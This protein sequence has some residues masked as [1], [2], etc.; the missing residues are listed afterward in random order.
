LEGVE[1]TDNEFAQV[2]AKVSQ[3]DNSFEASK[4]LAMEGST[5]KIDGIYRDDNPKVTRKQITLTIFK[6][7]EVRG[8]DSSYKIAREI[9]TSNNNRFDIVLLINGLP[10]INI[11]QKRSDKTLDEAFGQFKRYYKDGE[12]VN[13]FMAFSQ[14]MVITSE[15]ATRYFATPKSINDFNLSFVF[16]WADKH[17]KPINNWQ[18]IVARFLMIPMA[19]QL[20]GDYLIIDEAEDEEN[21]RH[22]IMRPYQVYALQAV[23]G[24]AFGW[25]NDD[26]IPHGGY[27]WHTTGERVIIVIGCINILVSRVSGTFI[28]NNS[29]IT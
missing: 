11:E 8:G 23:E 3:I 16:G 21:R 20:V 1:L 4:I 18:E 19:H 15:V 26:K 28:K 29:C 22:M 25:D 5:G 2:M 14:M 7:A 27:V 10:L 17:N 24:A 6:K 12:Y 9:T 13:N